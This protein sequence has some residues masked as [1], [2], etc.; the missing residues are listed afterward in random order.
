MLADE[1]RDLPLPLL[2]RCAIRL[3]AGPMLLALEIR[4][5][6]PER[7]RRHGGFLR[8]VMQRRGTRLRIV[9]S[10]PDALF[11]TGEGTGQTSDLHFPLSLLCSDCCLAASAAVA[12]RRFAVAPTRG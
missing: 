11:E 2:G 12:P 6:V 3:V 4:H 8:P 1:G 7:H 9:A 10:A 5:L